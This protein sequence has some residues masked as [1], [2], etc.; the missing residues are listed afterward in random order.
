[1]VL[2]PNPDAKAPEVEPKTTGIFF[3]N[4]D[5]DEMARHF[6]GNNFRLLIDLQLV[7]LFVY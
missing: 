6:I 3:E 7:L 5:L 4:H 1:M 2:L